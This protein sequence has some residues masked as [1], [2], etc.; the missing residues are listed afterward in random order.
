[1]IKIGWIHNWR[2]GRKRQLDVGSCE[3]GRCRAKPVF[4]WRCYSPISRPLYTHSSVFRLS[5]RA[6]TILAVPGPNSTTYRTRPWQKSPQNRVSVM[7]CELDS[8]QPINCQCE[9]PHHNYLFIIFLSPVLLFWKIACKTRVHD[10]HDIRKL[11]RP[12]R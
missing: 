7:H 5:C 6:T 8:P 4:S 11:N 10:V 3:W 9:M 12:I 2:I 1:M